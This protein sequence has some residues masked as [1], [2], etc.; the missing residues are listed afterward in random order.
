MALKFRK[1]KTNAEYSRSSSISLQITTEI[2]KYVML[3]S[4]CNLVSKSEIFKGVMKEWYTSTSNEYPTEDLISQIRFKI[5][6]EW[7]RIRKRK[8]FYT[9][10]D[11]YAAFNEFKDNTRK[12]LDKRKLDEKTIDI[13]LQKL[14][15]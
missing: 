11:K 9:P 12:L 2:Y 3:Y 8:M 10:E 7:N 4:A 15:A 6:T 1:N 5:Q 14:I 13:I